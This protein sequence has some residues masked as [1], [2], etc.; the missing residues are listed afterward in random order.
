[1]NLISVVTPCFNEELNIESVYQQVKD[2]L[3]KLPKYRYEHIFID[4]SSTDKTVEILRTFA[5][6]IKY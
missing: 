3:N 1:M 6:S 2:V 4:N 5:W